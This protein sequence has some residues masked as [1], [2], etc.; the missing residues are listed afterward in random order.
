MAVEIISRSGWSAVA[1]RSRSRIRTPSPELWLHHTAGN[2]SGAVGMRSIQQFHMTPKPSGRGWS[3][4]AYSFVIDPDTLRIY[5]GRGAGVLGA[6]TFGRNSI[7]HAICVMGNF[8]RERPPAGLVARVAELV[9]HGHDRGWW[10]ERLTGG[11]RDVSP[12][13]CPGDELYALIGEINDRTGAPPGGLTV[14]TP[15]EPNPYVKRA[16]QAF[17]RIDPSLLPEFG[18][19]GFAGAETAEAAE[20][21][22]LRIAD[23]RARNSA[24]TAEIQRLTGI[25]NERNRLAEA[26]E[27]FR[28][29]IIKLEP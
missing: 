3:D 22:A 19:D 23:L 17:L 8:D 1:P 2:H 15:N 9:A 24:G 26:A 25:V 5:E 13:S 18:A 12:T 16:Q 14:P 21:V 6:H 10:P 29:A 28:E 20:T 11:H 7:S 4:I 27:L